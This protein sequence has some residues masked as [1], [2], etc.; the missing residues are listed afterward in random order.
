MCRLVVRRALFFCHFLLTN[1]TTTI[2]LANR[3]FRRRLRQQDIALGVEAC[4]V[5]P[6]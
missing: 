6:H 3:P 5:K 2:L 4:G 1:K